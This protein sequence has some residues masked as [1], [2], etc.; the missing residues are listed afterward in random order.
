MKKRFTLSATHI[1][2][3]SFFMVIIIGSAILSIPIC[4]INGQPTPYIDSLF[5]A[6]TS[7]CVTGLTTVTTATHWNTLGQIVILILIQIGGLGVITSIA[8]ITIFIYKK[9]GM[10]NKFLLQDTMNIN[11]AF[12]I[13][14]FLKKV[15]VG[16]FAIEGIGTL[17]YMTVFVKEFGLIGIWYSLF[18][19][20]SAFCNAGIDIIADNSLSSFAT[21]PIINITTAF[22]VIMGGLG[23]IVWFDIYN[24]FKHKKR[25]SL[26]SKTAIGT[27]IALLLGGTILFFIFEY[28]NP[29]TIKNLSV[30]D[31][32]QTSFFQSMTTRTAGFYTIPQENFSNTSSII[33]LLLMFIGGSPVGT[34][35]GIKT[36]TIMVVIASAIATIKSQ[37]DTNLFNRKISKNIIRKSIA[38]LFVSFCTAFI[39]TLL[40]SIVCDRDFIDIIYETVS[41][42]ATVGLSRNLTSSL[43]VVGKLIIIFTMYLGRVGPISLALAFNVKKENKNIIKNPAEEICVG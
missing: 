38:V 7:T 33:S 17:L 14:P 29:A 11:T 2:L 10:T 42:T 27:T 24:F 5:T 16:T 1:L 32:L 34:A 43:N 39:S 31:K 20:I 26:H 21:N 9:L 18:T 15:I 12:D 4:S 22:L 8:G 23:Y 41:A 6:T 37:N 13:I 36:T 19:S 3:L 28:N 40:L 35:G 30:F 25:F